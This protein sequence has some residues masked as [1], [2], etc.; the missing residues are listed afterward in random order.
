M[1]MSWFLPSA[2]SDRQQAID[3]IV[4]N[5]KQDG[6]II[7]CI[8]MDFEMPILT[9]PEATK[10]LRELGYQGAILGVTGNVLKEDVDF[11]LSKGANDV[12]P[13]PVSVKLL[14]NYWETHRFEIE[15][16]EVKPH[17]L[18]QRGRNSCTPKEDKKVD[19][20]LAA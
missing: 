15:Q 10:K 17:A 1:L 11:F 6:I 14:N 5:R 13:K 16:D 12:L 9:G 4:A 20:A 18:D 7:D 19:G 2:A 3:A 8:M